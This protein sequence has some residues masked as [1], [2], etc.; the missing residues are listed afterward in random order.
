VYKLVLDANAEAS[1]STG[2]GKGHHADGQAADLPGHVRPN[3]GQPHVEPSFNSVL[4]SSAFF[5][6]FNPPV[7]AGP[8]E[9]KTGVSVSQPRSDANGFSANVITE[10]SSTHLTEQ[11]D[12]GNLGSQ[13][14]WNPPFADYWDVQGSEGFL[15]DPA[16]SPLIFPS[17]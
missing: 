8:N 12:V 14:P 13:R 15:Y 16:I 4:H 10:R 3:P 9:P 5:S 17:H 7:T 1:P 11:H 6:N 2:F